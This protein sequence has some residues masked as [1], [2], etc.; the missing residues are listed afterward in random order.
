ML[1]LVMHLLPRTADQETLQTEGI[2]VCLRPLN[3]NPEK[4]AA[5]S[6]YVTCDQHMFACQ[7]QLSPLPTLPHLAY[8]GP[9]L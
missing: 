2:L 8:Y 5:C 3:G 7:T 1:W 4:M 6:K 9:Q